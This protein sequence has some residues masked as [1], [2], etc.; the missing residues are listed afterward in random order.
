MHH[1]GG[2]IGRSA[3][4]AT[5]ASCIVTDVLGPACRARMRNLVW[6]TICFVSDGHSLVL[7]LGPSYVA[8]GYQVRLAWI[9]FAQRQ[10]RLQPQVIASRLPLVLLIVRRFKSCGGSMWFSGSFDARW[11]IADSSSEIVRPWLKGRN[12]ILRELCFHES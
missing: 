6:S 11:R 1:D 8:G 7:S 10:D 4:T 5:G 12:D 9:A 2:H 3:G